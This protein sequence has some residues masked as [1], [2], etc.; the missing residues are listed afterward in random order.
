MRM[1][2]EPLA[3]VKLPDQIRLVAIFVGLV[4]EWPVVAVVAKSFDIEAKH[5]AAIAD[6]PQPITFNERG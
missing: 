3:H 5:F 4:T 2:S 6:E 1:D